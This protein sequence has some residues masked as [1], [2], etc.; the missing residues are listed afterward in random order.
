MKQLDEEREAAVTAKTALE[1]KVRL[2]FFLEL[3][4]NCISFSVHVLYMYMYMYMYVVLLVPSQ[5]IVYMYM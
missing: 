4:Y 2:I 1:K 3:L 5:S